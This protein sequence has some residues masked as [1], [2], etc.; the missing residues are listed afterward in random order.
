MSQHKRPEWEQYDC[1][2]DNES[3]GSIELLLPLRSLV[4]P[5]VVVIVVCFLVLLNLDSPQSLD[6]LG[7][8]VVVPF[9]CVVVDFGDAESEEREREEF[10][11]VFGGCAVVYFGEEGVLGARFLVG[12]GL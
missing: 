1:D 9:V 12:R 7:L 10:E 2:N 3:A 11:D 4:Q 8:G 6:A 5:D